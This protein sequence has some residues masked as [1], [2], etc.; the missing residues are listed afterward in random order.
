MTDFPV[1]TED[2]AAHDS[3]MARAGQARIILKPPFCHYVRL[4][5]PATVG[6]SG[7][8]SEREPGLLRHQARA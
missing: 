5:L 6:S 8:F 1:F 3:E 2:Y 4:V 7:V